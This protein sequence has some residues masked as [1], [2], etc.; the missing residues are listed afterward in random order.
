VPL[1]HDAMIRLASLLVI[2]LAV[3]PSW[4]APKLKP[5]APEPPALA[6]TWTGLNYEKHTMTVEFRAG[7][8]MV[9]SYNGATYRNATWTQDGDKVYFEMNMK[10]CEFHGKLSGDSVEGESHNVAGLRWSTSLT[11][12]RDR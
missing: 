12:N 1:D 3:G 11:R 9:Y 8:E 6:G 10:Y 2:A 5:K 4:A 7:G